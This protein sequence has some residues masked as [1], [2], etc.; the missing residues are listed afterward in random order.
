MF[1]LFIN[2]MKTILVDAWNTFVTEEGIFR[3]MKG[4]LDGFENRKL[5]LTNANDEERVKFG[6]VDMPYEVFSLSHDPNKV[7]P[8]FYRKMLEYFKLDS[9]D[10]VCF[11][12]KEEAVKSAKSVGIISFHY[13]KDKKDLIALKKFIEENL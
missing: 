3:D 1:N 9:K 5:I 6:I 2:L 13:D 11:E 12:H 4:M 10:V 8:E 7:D